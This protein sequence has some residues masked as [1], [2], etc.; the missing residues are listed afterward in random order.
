M[1]IKQSFY[2]RLGTSFGRFGL[3]TKNDKALTAKGVKQICLFHQVFQSTYLFGAFS[4]ITGN[5]FMMELPHCNTANF[6]LFLNEFA[7]EDPT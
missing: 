2:T 1:S 5:Y 4:T 6:Q 7:K 3:F